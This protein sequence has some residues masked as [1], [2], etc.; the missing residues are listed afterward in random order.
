MAFFLLKLGQESKEGLKVAFLLLKL[1]LEIAPNP[2]LNDLFLKL[3]EEIA[4][5]PGMEP[6][7]NPV[8]RVLSLAVTQQGL[9]PVL[10]QITQEE[11]FNVAGVLYKSGQ[12]VA[13]QPGEDHGSIPIMNEE[14]SQ[15]TESV[16]YRYKSFFFDAASFS[17]LSP[18]LVFNPRKTNV[19]KLLILSISH[20]SY[21]LT[22]I[23]AQESQKK[24]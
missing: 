19:F 14:P 23:C 11:M 24:C 4:S 2:E 22:K 12:D 5:E 21:S 3:G 16:V 20:S 1:G 13:Q 18:N 6:G 9:E 15:S 7:L 10:V 17:S 8:L